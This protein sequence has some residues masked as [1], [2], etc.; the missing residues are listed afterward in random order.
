MVATSTHGAAVLSSVAIMRLTA[1]SLGNRKLTTVLTVLAI[2]LSVM[3]LL[4]VERLRTQARASFAHTIAGTDLIV[5]ARSG[6]IPL[7]LYSVFRIG[8]ATNNIGWDSYQAVAA[9]VPTT[10]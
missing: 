10:R 7:L 6:A 5:G 1:H 2:A 8:D 4:G 9:V 3:L